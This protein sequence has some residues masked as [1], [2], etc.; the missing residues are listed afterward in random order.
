[1]TGGQKSEFLTEFNERIEHLPKSV[2]RAAVKRIQLVAY[3]LDEG[4]R[5]PG[6][7]YRIGIDP[8]LGILPGAGDVL[9]GGVSLYIVVESARLGVS[10]TTLLRMIA[11]ISLD[12]AVGTIPIVGD[13]FDI[14]WKANKRN[15]KLVLED[16]TT[17]YDRSTRSSGE[18]TEIEIE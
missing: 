8:V 4:I 14:V 5:V 6:I 10:Y 9:S 2:D 17:D 11:N 16:L 7:G 13:A 3:V 15:F 1:M 12:V 18:R